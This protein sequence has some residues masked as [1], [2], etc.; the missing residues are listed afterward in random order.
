MADRPFSVWTF[1]RLRL[2]IMVV[3]HCFN[4]IGTARLYGVG[5]AV[6]LVPVYMCMYMRD[7]EKGARERK[8]RRSCMCGEAS[9]QFDPVHH[10]V[11][12]KAC[13]ETKL[14]GA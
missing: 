14:G 5:S 8:R 1:I 4:S 7:R 3:E 13:V 10:G 12:H 9:G 2:F 11:D 6:P